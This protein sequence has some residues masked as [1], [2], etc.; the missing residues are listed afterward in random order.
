MLKLNTNNKNQLSG[1]NKKGSSMKRFIYI[2][3]VVSVIVAGMAFSQDDSTKTVSPEKILTVSAKEDG[4]VKVQNENYFDILTA[5]Q[6]WTNISILSLTALI[7][8]I[9][10]FTAYNQYVIN[11]RKLK[12]T[13]E[14]HV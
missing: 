13:I 5:Y 4:Q 2:A 7:M 14:D 8:L 11:K 9:T 10:G 12:E 6:K 3:L 1:L